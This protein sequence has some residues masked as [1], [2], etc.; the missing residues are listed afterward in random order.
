MLRALAALAL[1]CSAFV[2]AQDRKS[3]V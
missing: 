3:V 2:S 1:L